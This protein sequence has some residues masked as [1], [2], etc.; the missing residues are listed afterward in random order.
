MLNAK[1]NFPP[2][3]RGRGRS[4][5]R[6]KES[7]L[8]RP[9]DPEESALAIL[10]V[11]A[12]VRRNDDVEA[13]EL[14]RSVRESYFDLLRKVQFRYVCAGRDEERARLTGR[15]RRVVRSR[16][17][18]FS[19]AQEESGKRRTLLQ[20]QLAR[21]SFLDPL[22]RVLRVLPPLPLLLLLLTSAGPAEH[23]EPRVRK[24]GDKSKEL[25]P[26]V[27]PAVAAPYLDREELYH[28]D[29]STRARP[30]PSHSTLPSSAPRTRSGACASVQKTTAA[31]V[32]SFSR[33]SSSRP[34]TRQSPRHLVG[35]EHF[36]WK[37]SGAKKKLF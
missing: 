24:S 2:L 5:E 4:R 26:L 13:V 31:R 12:L 37:T 27:G 8:A 19:R 28:G 9:K 16:V 33:R 3:Q 6:K 11:V 21:G 15:D 36:Q 7:D 18:S 1:L 25:Q 17:S 29:P 35:I 23:R 10:L 34:R 32:R 14:V 22:L 20:A 30:N